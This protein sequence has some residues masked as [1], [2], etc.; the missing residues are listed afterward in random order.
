MCDLV[1]VAALKLVVV[2]V[3]VVVIWNFRVVVMIMRKTIS[4][5]KC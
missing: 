3:V 2:V 5:Y 1:V 4:L